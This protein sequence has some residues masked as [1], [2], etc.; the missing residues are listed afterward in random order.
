MTW[1]L[2]SAAAFVLP[3]A[4]TLLVL[5]LKRPRHRILRS[6]LGVAVA[7]I[8]SVLFTGLV[9]NPVGEA[10]ATATFGAEYAFNRFDNN[11]IS[12]MIM[13]GWVLPLLTAVI[14]FGGSWA[15]RRFRGN[16]NRSRAQPP[17]L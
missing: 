4:L 15:W 14:F 6:A 5:L 1:T 2:V 11:T 17:A 7:W 13:S 12:V 16:A 8:V 10:H 9:Y 3:V